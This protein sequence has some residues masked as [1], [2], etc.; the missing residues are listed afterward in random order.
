[1]CEFRR[2]QAFCSKATLTGPRWGKSSSG[3]LGGGTLHMLRVRMTS[4]VSELVLGTGKGQV[5]W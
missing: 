4:R 1:M 2:G 5:Q 3:T